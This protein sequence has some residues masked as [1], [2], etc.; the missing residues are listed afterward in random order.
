MSAA[1]IKRDDRIGC[2]HQG[3]KRER[4]RRR[5]DRDRN[6]AICFI[7]IKARLRAMLPAGVDGWTIRRY[8]RHAAGSDT[9]QQKN[10]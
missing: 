4:N 9:R 5:E 1:C 7:L 8:M 6:A 3:R 10:N 2:L